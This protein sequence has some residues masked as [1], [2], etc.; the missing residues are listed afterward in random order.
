M[1]KYVYDQK[2][3]LVNKIKTREEV[4]ETNRAS[5][6]FV[7]FLPAIFL[8]IGIASLSYDYIVGVGMHSLIAFLTSLAAFAA[9]TYGFL[10]NRI[11][12][13]ILL[14]CA[15]IFGAIVV[16]LIA[17]R[18]TTDTIWIIFWSAI[19]FIAIGIAYY[20]WWDDRFN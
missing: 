3:N 19:Y 11:S 9:I 15:D 16:A 1:V 17:S 4:R 13:I 5:L 14:F 12:S 8:P 6:I 10:A 2:G 20:I 7:V 18:G